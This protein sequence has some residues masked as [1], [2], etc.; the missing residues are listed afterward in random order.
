MGVRFTPGYKLAVTKGRYTVQ[1]LPLPGAEFIYHVHG[2]IAGYDLE[3]PALLSVGGW[4]R[5]IPSAERRLRV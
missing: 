5:V 3:V 4:Y 1:N 2:V